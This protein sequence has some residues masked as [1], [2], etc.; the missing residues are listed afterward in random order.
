MLLFL[1]GE[2]EVQAP[3]PAAHWQETIDNLYP[4]PILP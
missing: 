3:A 1:G 2:I 4:E